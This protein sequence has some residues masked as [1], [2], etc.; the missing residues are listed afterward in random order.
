MAETEGLKS[1]LLA[2]DFSPPADKAYK[3]VKSMLFPHDHAKLYIIY[4]IKPVYAPMGDLTGATEVLIDEK[5]DMVE[6]IREKMK[7]LEIDA[8]KA[9]IFDCEG[10][11]KYGDPVNGII[12]E[13]ERIMPDMIVMGNRK[14]GFRRGILFGSVSE[15]VSADSP[16][17][18]LIV[19]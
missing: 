8:K 15:R 2:T 18:V 16:V 3:F 4:V 7:M 19:R 9:G 10:I 1:I 12:E 5:S 14:T 13:A 17:S 11:I 6:E